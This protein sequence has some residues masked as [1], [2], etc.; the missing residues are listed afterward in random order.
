MLCPANATQQQ[1]RAVN[2]F[3]FLPPFL[4]PG[5]RGKEAAAALVVPPR[6][7][8]RYRAMLWQQEARLNAP[9][10]LTVSPIFTYLTRVLCSGPQM[11]ASD[12]TPLLPVCLVPNTGRTAAAFRSACTKTD[13]LWALTE[14]EWTV[15]V[16]TNTRCR[17]FRCCLRPRRPEVPDQVPLQLR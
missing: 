16:Y 11:Y 15:H 9:C 1:A 5:S 3:S 2:S 13:G 8:T 4:P 7:S 6:H 12:E 14:L 17:G 10:W